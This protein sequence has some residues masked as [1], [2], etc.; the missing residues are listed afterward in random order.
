MFSRD[1][2]KKHGIF[3]TPEDVADFIIKRISVKKNLKILEPGCGSGI[4]VDLLADKLRN[5][6]LKKRDIFS[7]VI[8]CFDQQKGSI[9][10][11]RE[12]YKISGENYNI[13]RSNFFSNT[14]FDEQRFDYIIGNPPYGAKL[15]SDD[16]DYIKKNPEIFP[17]KSNESSVL[18]ICKAIHLLKEGGKLIFVLPATLLRVKAYAE[19][20]KFLKEETFLN[21]LVN[22]EKKFKGV[23]YETIILEATK[24]SPKIDIPKKITLDRKSVV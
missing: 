18:F 11:I 9:K 13:R 7:K 22:L 8:Y 23:G 15:T 1:Y 4:F 10:R 21:L 12:K 3:D 20:R 16:L 6:G 24:K 14:F 19:L 5:I 17:L 2:K